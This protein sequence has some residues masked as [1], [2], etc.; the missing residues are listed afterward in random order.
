MRLD[1]LDLSLT[2]AGKHCLS[3][4]SMHLSVCADVLHHV[5]LTLCDSTG[6]SPP[7]SS[8]HGILQAGILEWVALPSPGD[9]PDPGIEPGSLTSPV[10]AGRFLTARG[11]WELE[12]P[13]MLLKGESV[14]TQSCPALFHAMD[15]SLPGSS[16]H[17]ILQTGTLEWVAI[18]F[19]RGP[20]RLRDQTRVSHIMGR[21]FTIWATL[22]DPKY[23]VSCRFFCRCPVS[24]W[25]TFNLFLVSGVFSW[26]EVGFYQMLS[27]YLLK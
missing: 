2:L 16:G 27:L 18:P 22:M 20:S 26:K 11:T 6:C 8:V 14:L 3:A 7:G 17:E 9:L 23:A 5:W 4:W 12:P 21:F 25:E 13:S 1:I 15:C 24:V 10:L 19:F